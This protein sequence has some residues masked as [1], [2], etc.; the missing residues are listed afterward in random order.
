MEVNDILQLAPDNFAELC[1][2]SFQETSNPQFDSPNIND[3]D[4]HNQS[5]IP[6]S[7]RMIQIEPVFEPTPVYG[8]DTSNI[9]LGETCEGILCA[10]RGSIVWRE[11]N[12][13][14]YLRYGPFIFNIT[15]ENKFILYNTL[16]QIHLDEASSFDAPI[17][18][19]M[20]DRIR[21]VLERWMQ[22]QLVEI[23]YDSLILWDGSLTTRVVKSSKSFMDEL[24]YNARKNH[25]NIL[26]LSK[27]TTLS[28][29]GQRFYDLIEDHYA[30][31]LLDIDD[32]AHSQRGTQLRFFGRIYAA[33]LSPCHFTFRLDIDRQIP[34]DQRIHAV[35]QLLGNELLR[36]NYPETLR[37][38][39]VLSRFSSN[40]VIAMQRYVTENY[41]LR[42]DTRPNVRQ[43]LFGP[44][45]GM[46][47]R[48]STGYDASL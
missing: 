25:N 17:L 26:A 28:V 3:L 30:P 21:F 23:A 6:L 39:H 38:A 36:D 7:K 20:V 42:L 40:E 1:H 41:G 27:Q 47:Q 31:C 33:K 5:S 14:R 46:N 2:H 4:V 48:R 35:S 22:E 16:N 8:L 34:Q 37:L 9:V 12:K 11:N 44:Y 19:R 45:G 24:L 10:V 43:V 15:E 29:F 18:E 13:Y 32:I